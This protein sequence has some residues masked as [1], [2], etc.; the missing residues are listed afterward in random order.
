VKYH[1]VCRLYNLRPQPTV[2]LLSFDIR[3]E[4]MRGGLSIMTR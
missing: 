1:T 2:S 4:I 3:P